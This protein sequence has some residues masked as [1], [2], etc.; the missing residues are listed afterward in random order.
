MS[1]ITFWNGSKEQSGT[2]YSSIA[3]AVQSAIQ[4]NLKILLISTSLDNSTIKEC[5][6][7]EKGKKFFGGNTKT[8]DTSGVEG[9]ELL[10][11]GGKIS[12]NRIPEY[13]R[14]LLRDRLEVLEGVENQNVGLYEKIKEKYSQIIATANEYY[15]LVV[16][17]LDKGLG[18]KIQQE[19]INISDIVVP[20]ITQKMKDVQRIQEIIEKNETLKKDNT[21]I[22]LGR[23]MDDSKYN[24][25][26]ITR[27][28]LR[29]RDLV[30]TVPYSTL[31][32]EA[33]QEGR[34]IDLFFDFM[35]IKEKDENYKFVQELNR[36]FTIAKAKNDM[37]KMKRR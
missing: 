14:V 8:V 11:R 33:A 20:V 35:K 34:V 10:M 2:T 29:T 27:S 4:H 21:V 6:W 15:N 37:L 24:A 22:T 28:L 30:N 31:F 36:L 16:V 1:I 26:N 19:I 5:F 32:F 23:Y 18:E 3:F 9:L 7:K 13:T 25:K 17:D 12:P